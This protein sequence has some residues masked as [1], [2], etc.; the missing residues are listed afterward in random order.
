MCFPSTAFNWEIAVKINRAVPI[1]SAPNL[2]AVFETSLSIFKS[3]SFKIRCSFLLFSLAALVLITTDKSTTY[4]DACVCWL[5]LEDSRSSTIC[6]FV[7]WEISLASG[8]GPYLYRVLFGV[9][10]YV[11]LAANI[12]YKAVIGNDIPEN[13]L[14]PTIKNWYGT[15]QCRVFSDDLFSW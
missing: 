9:S 11:G 14:F 1:S 2:L 12:I 6:D 8:C 10:M 4:T 7:E 5:R 15:N 3:H 13:P